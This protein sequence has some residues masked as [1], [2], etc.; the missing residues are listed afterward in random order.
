MWQLV[1]AFAAAGKLRNARVDVSGIDLIV[2][3]MAGTT[4]YE[5]GI[6]YEALRSALF[7]SGVHVTNEEMREWHGADKAHA[8][9]HF[10]M[11]SKP[12]HASTIERSVQARFDDLIDEAYFGEKSVLRAIDNRLHDWIRC[13][14]ESGVMIALDTGYSK[15]TQSRIIEKLG[16][17]VDAYVSACEVRGGRPSPYMIFRCMERLG[18]TD[19]RRVAKVGDTVRDVQMGRNAGCGLVIGVLSGA[20]T[21]DD[22][23][24]AG[25]DVV[26]GSVTDI[27]TPQ[28]S[29]CPHGAEVVTDA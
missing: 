28:G 8:I 23:M 29:Y 9:R 16:L 21:Y 20:D 2:S 12:S 24:R 15:D 25:A 7:T 11:R 13:M 18:V 19:V 5:A 6:V 17:Q 14:R 27:S 3:D 1:V 22:L 4:V 26:I 10:A